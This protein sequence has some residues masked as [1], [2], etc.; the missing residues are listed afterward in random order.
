MSEMNGSWRLA[1]RPVGEITPE[2]FSWHEEPLPPLQ[3]GEVRIRVIY[4]SLDPAM[5]GWLADRKSYVPPVQIGEVMRGAVTAQV[6]ESR[7]D[8]FQ[9]GDYVGANT[10][11]QQY[12]NVPA[13]VL[14][15]LPA[16]IPLTAHLAVL[17][18]IGLTAY[19]GLLDIGQ[20]QPGE[21]LVISAAAGAVGSL[22]GQI[23][24]LKGCRVIGIA[25]SDAKCGWL[26]GELG[27]DGAINYKT[28]NVYKALRQHCPDGIDI[29]F[30]NVGGEIL[31]A[32]LAQVNV[33]ARIPLCGLISQY[34]A[35]EPVPGP[36]NFAS[37]LV[38]R[39]RLQGFIVHDYWDRGPEAFP[40]LATWLA[41]GQLQYRVDVVEGL[42]NAP[43]AI[44]RLFDGRKQGKLLVQVAAET[45]GAPAG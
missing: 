22:V 38:N 25:G 13:R 31:D 40:E 20:P 17:S 1:H 44:N 36:Y 2:V 39:V 35:T 18:H 11:W 6:V 21:T 34:N 37:L 9:P 12:A 24:K 33:G 26:T 27:F 19:F 3:D 15:P 5:R 14:T 29:Y 4:L 7:S 28:E 42:E 8:R 45:M 32:V 43:E 23:G 16:G 41:A 10:G 30:E